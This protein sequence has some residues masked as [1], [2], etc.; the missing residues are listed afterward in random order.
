[1]DVPFEFIC[2][3]PGTSA[4]AKASHV[5]SC[6]SSTRHVAITNTNSMAVNKNRSEDGLVVLSARCV[7]EDFEFH[8]PWRKDRKQLRANSQTA[9]EAFQSAKPL[10]PR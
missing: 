7:Q 6:T 2:K 5:K 10:M 8:N 4:M 9:R 3:I 1:M